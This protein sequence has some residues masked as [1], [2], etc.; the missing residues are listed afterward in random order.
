MEPAN[1]LVQEIDSIN[2][3]KIAVVILAWC[4][5]LGMASPAWCARSSAE[6]VPVAEAG[7]A[8]AVIVIPNVASES[9]EWAAGDSQ[10]ESECLKGSHGVG[11]AGK[12]ADGG[13]P[14]DC[15]G[16]TQASPHDVEQDAANQP[17]ARVGDLKCGED[18]GEVRV[19][20]VQL[21]SDDWRQHGEGLAADVVDHR[22]AKERVWKRKWIVCSCGSQ[23]HTKSGSH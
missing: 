17:H 4:S 21:P 18:T 12:H 6:A 2:C 23:A 13:P 7:Q 5:L 15:H 19:A 1:E 11:N 16:K 3:L 20:E 9:T 10:K 8:R 22:G 14:N